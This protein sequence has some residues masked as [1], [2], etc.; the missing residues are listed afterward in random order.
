[1]RRNLE[2]EMASN[3]RWEQIRDDWKEIVAEDPDN[4]EARRQH[5]DTESNVVSKRARKLLADKFD[6]KVDFIRDRGGIQ[7]TEARVLKKLHKYRN[8]LYHRDHIRPKTIRSAGLLYFDMICTLFERLPQ[9]QFSIVTIHMQAPAELRKFSPAG[10]DGYPTVEQIAASLRSGLGIDDAALKKAL[11]AHLTARLDDLDMAISRVEGLLFGALP[12]LAPSDPWRQLVIHL[13]QW[14]DE[15]LPGSFDELLAA[16]VRYWE[17]DLA[18][19]RQMVTGMQDVTARLEL[20]AAFAD[21]ED[22]FEPFEE[23]MMALDLRLELEIQRDVDM[24]R[25]K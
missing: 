15:E 24:R 4:A 21:T 11:T 22:A 8:E 18:A 2:R 20:F 25:G 17:A 6:L 13:A 1:M 7:E 23:R 12:E 9:A 5:D 3:R 10:T 19:W 14:E 16:Q